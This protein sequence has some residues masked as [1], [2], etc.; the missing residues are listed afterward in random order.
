MNVLVVYATKRGA[1]RGIVERIAMRLSAAGS[2][3]CPAHL[4][5]SVLCRPGATPNRLTELS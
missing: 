5:Q 2:S 4:G 3:A 1:T